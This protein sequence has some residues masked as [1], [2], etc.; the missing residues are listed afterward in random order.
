MVR[1]QRN[2][3]GGA[4]WFEAEIGRGEKQAQTGET[5]NAAAAARSRAPQTGRGGQSS[6]KPK[7]KRVNKGFQ[8]EEGR[9]RAWDILVA[10]M[11]SDPANRKT[12]PELID[13]AMDYVLK[14]YSS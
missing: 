13:E 2:S 9:A 8:V 10:K 7:V 12:G 14:K 5:V 11:K 4:D 6:N 1:E 3:S